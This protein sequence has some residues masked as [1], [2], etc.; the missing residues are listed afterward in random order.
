MLGY[1]F[2]LTWLFHFEIYF[3]FYSYLSEF[4][5]YSIFTSVFMLSVYMNKAYCSLIKLA[6]L[7]LIFINLINCVY[8]CFNISYWLYDAIIWLIIGFI[9]LSYK[10]NLYVR[11]SD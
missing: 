3:T 6:V 9:L 10:L 11:A 8:L 2:I 1:S 5:G 7:S 4:L